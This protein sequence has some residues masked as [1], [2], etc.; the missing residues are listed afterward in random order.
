MV[1]CNRNICNQLDENVCFAGSS[2]ISEQSNDVLSR[3]GTADEML[4][5]SA[6][7]QPCS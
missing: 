2:Q 3:P 1:L 5:G 7:P 6:H 4:S